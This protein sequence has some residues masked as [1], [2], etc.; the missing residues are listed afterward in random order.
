VPQPEMKITKDLM[1]FGNVRRGILGVRT[2]ATAQNTTNVIYTNKV[3]KNSGA[4]NL[5]NE[6]RYYC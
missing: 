4:E 6:R 3:T 2:N 5:I 1:E